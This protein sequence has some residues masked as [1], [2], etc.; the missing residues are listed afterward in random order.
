MWTVLR[1]RRR[2][3][4]YGRNWSDQ[5]SYF[6]PRWSGRLTP[7]PVRLYLLWPLSVR[8][9]GTF[10]RMK[11]LRSMDL[12]RTRRV[13]LTSSWPM[14]LRRPEISS[15][16]DVAGHGMENPGR[17]EWFFSAKTERGLSPSTTLQ[18][19]RCGSKGQDRYGETRGI[20][21]LVRPNSDLLWG[22]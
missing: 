21:S 6:K 4:C 20:V 9:R 13:P 15:R 8:Q 17:S 11:K 22:S 10:S 12:N 3:N 18:T 19:D 7:S 14:D 5:R 1:L 2:P 16:P